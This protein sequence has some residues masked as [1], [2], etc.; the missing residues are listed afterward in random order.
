M[1]TRKMEK[2]LSR[3]ITLQKV[4]IKIYSYKMQSKKPNPN[5]VIRILTEFQ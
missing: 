4:K 3:P 1:L 5:S 2:T